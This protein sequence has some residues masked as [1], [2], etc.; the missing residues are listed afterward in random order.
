VKKQPVDWRKA[1]PAPVALIFGPQQ[2]LANRAVQSIRQALSSKLGNVEVERIN[3]ADYSSGQL[4]S[5]SAPSL[6]AEP[7]F[8]I[9]SAVEKCSDDFILDGIAYLEN[10]EPDVTLVML[11]DGSSVRGKKLLDAVRASEKAIE[12]LAPKI[13]DAEKAA[14]V[15]AEFAAAGRPIAPQAVAALSNAFTDASELAAACEQ[16]MQD[17]SAN[18]TE[19]LVDEYYGGRV[20]SN[21]FKV[22]DAAIAG[23]KVQALEYLRHALLSGSDPVAL[24]MNVAYSFRPM[25]KAYGNRSVNAQSL[26]VDPW[27]LEKIRKGLVGFTDESMARVVSAIAE[28]DA[29][30]KGG[31]RDPEYV[32]EQLVLLIA[33]KGKA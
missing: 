21:G 13:K 11:H 31:S 33:N 3:A 24:A 7:K 28:A 9:V 23:Q 8:I 18:I 27:R 22:M 1:V 26:G 29:A 30:T 19:A 4:A 16:L 32:L 15:Q 10:I 6:F 14:F 20:E 5:V 17:N 12:V 2:F 25:A